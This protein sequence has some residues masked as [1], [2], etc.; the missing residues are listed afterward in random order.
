[1]DRQSPKQKGF[2]KYLTPGRVV[3]LVSILLVAIFLI[4]V[5]EY[6][7]HQYLQLQLEA[8][9]ISV[10]RD[11]KPLLFSF[12]RDIKTSETLAS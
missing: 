10:E 2:S 4:P 1:M 12:V 6:L 9:R 8:D 3:G 5:E 11:F 7:T